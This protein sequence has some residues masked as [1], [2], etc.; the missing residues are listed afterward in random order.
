M[1]FESEWFNFLLCRAAFK[2]FTRAVRS[3]Q[4]MYR[5]LKP[6]G[7]ALITDLQKDVSKESVK[8]VDRMGLGGV[9]TVIRKLAFRFMLSSGRTRGRS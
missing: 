3:L 2:N 7:K 5:V 6:G 8:A 9:N 1:P 4:E